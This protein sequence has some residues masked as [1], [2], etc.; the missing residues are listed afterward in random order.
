MPEFEQLCVEHLEERINWANFVEYTNE[1]INFR[2]N[3]LLGKCQELFSQYTSKVLSRSSFTAL[4]QPALSALLDV[5]EADVLEIKIFE[6]VKE[7]MVKQCSDNNL[8]PTGENMRLFLG[9]AIYKIRFP[10]MTVQD[11][12]NGVTTIP[13]FLTDSEKTQ[14]FEKITVFNKIVECPFPDK[15]RYNGNI[16]QHSLVAISDLLNNPSVLAQNVELIDRNVDHAYHPT[17]P[18]RILTQCCAD[19]SNSQYFRKTNHV[20]EVNAMIKESLSDTFHKWV[21]AKETG[22]YRQFIDKSRQ[23]RIKLDHVSK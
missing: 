13:G 17:G 12:A 18:L 15:P 14:I 16:D 23:L 9:S 7:W 20:N 21:V 3:A 22:D 5:D 10:T 1:A 6:H 4:S 19:L 2:S 11:F 8:P